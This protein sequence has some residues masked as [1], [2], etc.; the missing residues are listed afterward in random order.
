MTASQQN[1]NALAQL[2]PAHFLWIRAFSHAPLNGDGVTALN[3]VPVFA[4][5]SKVIR[6]PRFCP[7]F[8]FLSTKN[9]PRSSQEKRNES[10]ELL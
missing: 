8:N 1:V 6:L 2:R 4:L 3:W 9:S 5:Q 7:L 10:Q